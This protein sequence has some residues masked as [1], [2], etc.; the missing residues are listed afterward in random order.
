VCASALR[1]GEG[2][3]VAV[4]ETSRR[5]ET[6]RRAGGPTPLEG[7]VELRDRTF[8]YIF[9]LIFFIFLKTKSYD[10]YLRS[11]TPEVDPKDVRGARAG[12]GGGRGGVDVLRAK[13]GGNG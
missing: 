4:K 11:A 2:V 9:F 8:F 5:E 10:V 3:R 13:E 6:S 12:G 1:G 7:D